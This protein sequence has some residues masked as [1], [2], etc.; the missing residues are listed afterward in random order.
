MDHSDPKRVNYFWKLLTSN[1]IS[2]ILW[3]LLTPLSLIPLDP[4]RG[5]YGG[6]GLKKGGNSMYLTPKC[7]MFLESP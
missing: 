6:G 1:I 5:A 4:Y 3:G 7:D 2:V